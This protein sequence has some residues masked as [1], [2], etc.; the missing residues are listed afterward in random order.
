M[1]YVVDFDVG[2]CGKQKAM[3]AESVG[4]AV[5][6]LSGNNVGA[7]CGFEG[8]PAEAR[9]KGIVGLVDED[10]KTASNDEVT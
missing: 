6:N 10:L 3:H 4:S 5:N 1:I 9:K 8:E 7:G 2:W